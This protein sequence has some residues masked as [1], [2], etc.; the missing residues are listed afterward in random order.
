M[1]RE[2]LHTDEEYNYDD[3]TRLVA[4]AIAGR[5]HAE[6]GEQNLQDRAAEIARIIK[7]ER[8]AGYFIEYVFDA[9]GRVLVRVKHARRPVTVAGADLERRRVQF[10]NAL[11][12]FEKLAKELMQHPH[13]DPLRPVGERLTTLI[14]KTRI[15]LARY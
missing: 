12:P 7:Q 10:L 11:K 9:H 2:L 15:E 14:E 4:G 13:D 1:S 5:I 3:S 8:P 6:L